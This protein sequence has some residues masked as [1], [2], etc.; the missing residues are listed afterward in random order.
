[1]E[2]VA[3]RSF[4]ISITLNDIDEEILCRPVHDP[5]YQPLIVHQYVDGKI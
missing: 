3:A 5:I 1:M 4:E 2:N